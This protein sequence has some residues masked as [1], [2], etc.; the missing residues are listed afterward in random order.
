MISTRITLPGGPGRR[1]L[2]FRRSGESRELADHWADP[3]TGLPHLGHG[4][5]MPADEHYR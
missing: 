5:I 2:I 1:H 4:A 3:C